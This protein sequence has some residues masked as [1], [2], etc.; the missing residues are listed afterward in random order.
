[1]KNI[2]AIF[3]TFCLA[4]VFGTSVSATEEF[5]G[6]NIMVAFWEER[7][8][9]NVPSNQQEYYRR[10]GLPHGVGGIQK[11]FLP[12]DQFNT[13][14]YLNKVGTV[15]RAKIE[16]KASPEPKCFFWSKKKHCSSLFSNGTNLEERHEDSVY[17]QCYTL[18]SPETQIVLSVE[19]RFEI[20]LVKL[21]LQD[22][23][24]TRV[25]YSDI[26]PKK[27]GSQAPSITR[28]EIL[29]RPGNMDI[30]CYISRSS[31]PNYTEMPS[32]QVGEPL[33]EE[34]FMPHEIIC[35]DETSTFW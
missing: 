33:D 25:E 15:L 6:T 34:I 4:Y 28:V 32:A 19:N 7:V 31:S 35:R 21:E 10:E 18:D 13:V 8:A 22:D 1:M 9:L 23:R 26:F 29:D 27:H 30:V 20:E 5:D 2:I 24:I 12:E 14:T 16:N 17:M 11:I 3:S